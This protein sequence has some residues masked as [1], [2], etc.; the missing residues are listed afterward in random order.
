MLLAGIT[1][2][3]CKKQGDA[4]LYPG[5]GTLQ[6]KGTVPAGTDAFTLQI[7]SNKPDSLKPKASQIDVTKILEQ[8]K[9]RVG[10][11][12]G[13]AALLDTTLQFPQGSTQTLTFLYTGTSLLFDDPDTT[14]KPESG[15]I[16]VRFA[17]TDNTLPDKMNIEIFLYY[18]LSGTKTMPLN[19]K[20]ENI[21]KDRF[22]DYV[23]LSNPTK[24]APAGA[25]NARFV[26]EGYNAATQQK[27]MAI[28][29]NSMS[30][31]KLDKISGTGLTYTPNAVISLGIGAAVGSSKIHVPS[32]IFMR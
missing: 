17:T 31:I 5:F 4:I 14:R 11:Y 25:T 2:L 19:I 21:S 20:L 9:R 32:I 29:D 12:K 26:I 6:L 10:I 8:G 27:V 15:N 7:D 22:S 1:L 28:S 3:S 24:L 18:T 13:N 16:L 23:E 30:Y